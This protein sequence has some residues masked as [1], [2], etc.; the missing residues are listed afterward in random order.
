MIKNRKLGLSGFPLGN[1]CAI[2][3][4]APVPER[5]LAQVP[6]GQKGQKGQ[7]GGGMGKMNP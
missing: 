5:E 4:R 1:T 6:R 2:L 7:A 3:E